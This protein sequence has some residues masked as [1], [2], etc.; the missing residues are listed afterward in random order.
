MAVDIRKADRR[1]EAAHLGLELISERA[2]NGAWVRKVHEDARRLLY[3]IQ[4]DLP[5]E[6]FRTATHLHATTTR[7]ARQLGLDPRKPVA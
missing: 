2:E 3:L 5:L 6:A 4:A 7:R 1:T